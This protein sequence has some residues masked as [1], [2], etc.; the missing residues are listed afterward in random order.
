[1]GIKEAFL[2]EIKTERAISKTLKASNK[3]L[4]VPLR[5]FDNTMSETLAPVVYFIEKTRRIDSE[6][7]VDVANSVNEVFNHK[8]LAKDPKKILG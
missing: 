8:E 3:T 4:N 6:K 1:M 2:R 7:I 5:I